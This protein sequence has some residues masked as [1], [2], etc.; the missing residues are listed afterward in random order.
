[1]LRIRTAT[2]SFEHISHTVRAFQSRGQPVI[3]VD[4]KKKE[5]VGAFKN[6]GREWRPKGNPDT[7][8]IY[9]FLDPKLGKAIPYG[10]YDLSSNQ[11]WC[12]P[13]LSTS[14]CCCGGTWAP[15]SLVASAGRGCRRFGFISS[16]G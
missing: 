8:K 11:G 3:S 13:Q 14:V 5:L 15:A 4:T 10:V 1:V 9:D 2:P 12:R 16:P 7:V 6:V